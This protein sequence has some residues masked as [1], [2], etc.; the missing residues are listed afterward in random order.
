[1][2]GA[3]IFL[4]HQSVGPPPVSIRYVGNGNFTNGPVFGN[5]PSANPVLSGPTFA[6][7]NCSS[8]P[9]V[10]GWEIQV[11]NGTNWISLTAWDPL[12]EYDGPYGHYHP[13][14]LAPNTGAYLTVQFVSKIPTNTWR[15]YGMTLETL[16]GPARAFA[17]LRY[18]WV[19][20]EHQKVPINSIF[21]QNQNY[22]GN[23]SFFVSEE[24]LDP[25]ARQ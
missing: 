1:V 21:L 25:K 7:T 15:L 2:A 3:F 24:V 5:F 4:C 8:K 11:R 9:K 22:Y 17:A 10:V 13:F 20:R 19:W 14:G 16:T 18:W 6:I 12:I 23:R